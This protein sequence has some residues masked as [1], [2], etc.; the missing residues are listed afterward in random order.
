MT[1]FWTFFT[2]CLPYEISGAHGVVV[3]RADS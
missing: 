3:Q 2:G 1:R